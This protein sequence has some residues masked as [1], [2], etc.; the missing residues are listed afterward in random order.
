MA[1]YVARVPAKATAAQVYDYLANFST[2]AEWDPGV[3]SA[4]LISG[5]PATEGAVYRVVAVFGPRKIPLDYRVLFAK[6]PHSGEPG[7]ILL[8]AST[9][10][11]SSRDIIEVSETEKGC[12]AVYDATLELAGLRQVADPFMQLAFNIVGRRAENG[13]ITAL[14]DPK[15]F[16]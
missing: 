10:E 1:H 2:I 4:E 7:C 15:R 11:F 16:I 6:A 8:E 5:E 12:V 9:S 3:S 14:A 13:L